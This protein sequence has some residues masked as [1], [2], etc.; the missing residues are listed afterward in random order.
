V[1]HERGGIRC[2]PRK[3]EET[4]PE[5]ASLRSKENAYH[6]NRGKH[7]EGK[8]KDHPVNEKE[9]FDNKKPFII[10]RPLEKE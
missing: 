10:S 5:S 9:R 2:R 1:V 8:I 7:P 3:T 6:L 4:S